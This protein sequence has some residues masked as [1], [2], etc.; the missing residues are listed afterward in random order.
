MVSCRKSSFAH[1][2]FFSYT[3]ALDR[4]NNLGLDASP[5]EV[6][7]SAAVIEDTTAMIEA[8]AVPIRRRRDILWLTV[9]GA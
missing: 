5:S 2:D 4:R 1:I 8:K 9:I 3:W 7:A 6:S